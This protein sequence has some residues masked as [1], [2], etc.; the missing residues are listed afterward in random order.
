MDHQLANEEYQ[1]EGLPKNTMDDELILHS[2][3]RFCWGLEFGWSKD[4][5]TIKPHLVGFPSQGP[6]VTGMR[7]RWH[8]GMF[9]EC[10]CDIGIKTISG[11][12]FMMPCLV[13]FFQKSTAVSHII[14]SNILC[15]SNFGFG[16]RQRMSPFETPGDHFSRKM[17]ESKHEH[18]DDQQ[19][20]TPSN[21]CVIN[22]RAFQMRS[23]FLAPPSEF[24]EAFLWEGV[25]QP[26]EGRGRWFGLLSFTCYLPQVI[27]KKPGR[28]EFPSCFISF[29]VSKYLKFGNLAPNI[30]RSWSFCFFGRRLD[31]DFCLA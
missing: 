1:A 8:V 2:T 24:A 17:V 30:F 4:D 13:G 15:R 21:T 9:M 5:G 26:L 16:S 27:C 12:A 3:T 10:F 11:G 31:R 23:R 14:W 22:P 28:F 6:S 20:G 19:Q 25:Q 7:H 29:I 18:P